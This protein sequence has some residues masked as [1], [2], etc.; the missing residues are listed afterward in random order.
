MWRDV[1]EHALDL[2]YQIFTALE[3]QGTLNPDNEVHLF[4]LYQIFLPQIQQSLNSF[5]DAW[6][7]HGNSGEDTESKALWRILLRLKKMDGWMDG[8]NFNTFVSHCLYPQR[9]YGRK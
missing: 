7:I 1:Y 9:N 3:D 4:A 5:R 2:I 6:N 8:W